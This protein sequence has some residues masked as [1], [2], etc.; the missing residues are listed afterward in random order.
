MSLNNKE[1]ELF[2]RIEKIFQIGSF[3][4]TFYLSKKVN[5]VLPEFG[6][7]STFCIV[8]SLGVLLFFNI[9]IRTFSTKYTEHTISRYEKIIKGQKRKINEN[10]RTLKR[11]NK[12]IR[13]ARAEMTRIR[14]LRKKEKL[15]EWFLSFSFAIISGIISGIIANV[16]FHYFSILVNWS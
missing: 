8:V 10:K 14:A 16:F 12:D 11:I 5:S 4:C 6:F 13:I 2:S 15:K 7:F 1:R 3:V 9:V